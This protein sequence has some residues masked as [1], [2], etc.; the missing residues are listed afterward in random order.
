MSM[1]DRATLE[2]RLKAEGLD[3]STWSSLAGERFD[4]RT[5]DFDRIVVVV[6]GSITY[7]LSGYGVGYM[8]NPGG[9]GYRW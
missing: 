1:V 7:G 2:A 4:Q 5:N 6:E 9:R 8:L 3:A